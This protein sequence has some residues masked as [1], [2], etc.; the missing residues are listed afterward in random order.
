[1]RERANRR[2]VARRCAIAYRSGVRIG[3]TL[4]HAKALSPSVHDEPFDPERDNGALRRLALWASRYAPTVGLD[5]HTLH[6]DEGL[7]APACDGLLLDI[8]GCAHLFGGERAMASA[9]G[10]ALGRFGL[11]WRIGIAPT[12]G[13]A[14]AAARY[15]TDP[16]TI[17]NDVR[18]FMRD[19]PVRSLRLEGRV[20]SALNELGLERVG[21]VMDLPRSRLPVR[22]GDA[23]TRRIDQALGEAMELIEPVRTPPPVRVERLFEGP[24]TT[25]TEAIELATRELLVEL[26]RE[27]ARHE[28]GVVR[29]I[30]CF[31]RLMEDARRTERTEVWV[32]LSRAS[33]DADHLWSLLRSRVEKLHL[34]LGI[35]S[36]ALIASRTGAIRHAQR[37]QWTTGAARSFVEK[38]VGELVDT[39]ASRVGR[40]LR[41]EAGGSHIPEREVALVDVARENA[42]SRV[43]IDGDLG[44]LIGTHLLETERPTSLFERAEEA[45]AVALMPDRPPSVVRWRGRELRVR[46][47]VGP[48]RIGGE[49]WHEQERTRDYFRVQDQEGVW[50]WVYREAETGRWFVQGV[51]S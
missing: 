43:R 48:E 51:W 10:D 13:S 50:W 38:E 5:P 35:E 16:V 15:G 37:E 33:R 20:A 24:P 41:V 28:R 44:E 2:E 6:R 49:W 30:A 42:S 9:L 29:L 19:L 21:Q 39:L 7:K 47:G 18:P 45:E 27:L 17:V 40:V 36:I 32:A 23:L 11:S 3:M 22:F 34:G 14:W 25:Q 1:V 31:E 46:V 8:E 4:A 26:G 12:I